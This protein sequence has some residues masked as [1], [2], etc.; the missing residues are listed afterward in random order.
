MTTDLSIRRA[1]L[2]RFLAEAFL[3]PTENWVEEVPDLL[4]ILTDLGLG[5]YP[6]PSFNF[7]LSGL[8]QEHLHTFGVTGS[9]CYETEYGLA[10][11][12]RQ[13]QEMADIAGFYQAFGFK[14]GGKQRERPDH[15]ATELEFLYLL[16]LKEAY[17]AEQGIEEHVEVC[18]QA[19]QAFL[20]DHL[21]RWIGLVAQSL[22]KLAGGDGQSPYVWLANL[23]VAFVEA[24]AQSLGVTLSAPRL[25]E[26]QHTPLGPDLTCDSCPMS[27]ASAPLHTDGE[28]G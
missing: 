20:K 14:V 3:Y 26:V 7:Q 12:F 6:L 19:R 9:L 27:V 4:P 24:D 25:E 16:T 8:Q 15:L 17:A 5:A 10:G 2:Y 21:G 23:A 13:S 1:Q 28:H 22:S 18:S 11:E